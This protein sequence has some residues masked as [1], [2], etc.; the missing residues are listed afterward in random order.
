MNKDTDDKDF[1]DDD[2]EEDS[3]PGPEAFHATI[4]DQTH[5]CMSDRINSEISVVA[6]IHLIQF[7]S[8]H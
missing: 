7:L 1:E 6:M 5:M 2:H 8:L 4:M 3:D